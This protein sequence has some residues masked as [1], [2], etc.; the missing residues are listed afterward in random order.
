MFNQTRIHRGVCMEEDILFGE[1]TVEDMVK[2]QANIRNTKGEFFNEEIAAFLSLFLLQAV[3]NQKIKTLNEDLRRKVS[4]ANCFV[5]GTTI[6]LLD[7]PFENI[8]IEDREILAANIRK[9]AEKRK[10]AVI[11]ATRDFSE[12]EDISNSIGNFI[13]LWKISNLRNAY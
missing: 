3:R 4:L 5:G 6:V 12:A 1:L 11:W 8:K 9:I 2:L 7:N 10:I 13:I